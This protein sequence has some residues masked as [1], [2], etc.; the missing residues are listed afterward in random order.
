MPKGEE[1]LFIGV[2]I[3]ATKTIAGLVDESGR[4]L[5]RHRADT[6]RAADQD[7]TVESIGE[8]VAR[9]A[10]GAGVKVRD[11]RGLG[12]GVP[13]VV[14]PEAGLVVVTPN[15]NLNGVE[16]VS[17][18]EDCLQVPIFLG[19]DVNLGTL[20]EKWLGAA[21]RASSAFGIF[22]G[23]GI[24]GGIVADGG[25]LRGHREAAGEVG[26]IVMAVD[27]PLCGCGNRGCLEALAS[28]TAI[29]R[30]LREAVAQGKETALTAL[31]G[32]KPTVIKSGALRKALAQGDPLVT[33]VIGNAAR[34]LGFACVTVR[35]LL[36]PERIILGGG[37]IEA[38]GEFMLPIVQGIVAADALPGARPGGD[39][40]RSEL[41][42]DAVMLG[43][44]ALAIEGVTGESLLPA[45]GPLPDYPTINY[46]TFG[47]IALDKR[48]FKT[49]IYIRCDGK[50]KKRDKAAVREQ[51]G[52]S[53][54][55]G[56]EELMTV[57]KGDPELLVIGTGQQG[58]VNLT[59]EAARYLTD[60]S[61]NYVTHPSRRAATVYNHAK[62][63]KALLVH[64]NC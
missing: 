15:M 63:R 40:V 22:V 45:A 48:T 2:D 32:S 31:L 4:V 43:A 59:E 34:I 52:T 54:T 13:G 29:E 33:E 41:G 58:M 46:T 26:H 7:Q 44:A 18:L 12:I 25:L 10:E 38:C 27:G 55:V 39:V 36:D 8:A 57:C 56:V 42:D 49:D 62:G 9:L 35:H 11:V 47:E 14:D 17:R 23:T 60:R 50:V 24:G 20:G 64:V 61:I 51:Y 21:R 53:H 16:L 5:R 3:G 30:D 6:P 28:R 1:G 37:V 19:N